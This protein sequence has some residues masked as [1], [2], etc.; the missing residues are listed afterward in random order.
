MCGYDHFLAIFIFW[1]RRSAV[2]G[3]C[4]GIRNL[5]RPFCWIVVAGLVFSLYFRVS[6]YLNTTISLPFLFSGAFV[7]LVV[8]VAGSFE[9]F[10]GSSVFS[11]LLVLFPPLH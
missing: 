8:A 4:N 10:L 3:N 9:F 5:S 2:R 6:K 1:C 7:Q 11:L